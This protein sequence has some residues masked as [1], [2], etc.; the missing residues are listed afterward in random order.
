MPPQLE[1]TPLTHTPQ[2]HTRTQ[3]R[4]TSRRDLNVL[5]PRLLQ[6]SK[7]A[8]KRSLAVRPDGERRPVNVFFMVVLSEHM[9]LHKLLLNKTACCNWRP[10][11]IVQLGFVVGKKW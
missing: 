6:W 5:L 7:S 9:K 2:T 4:R 3:V 8:I 10:D 11:V 1:S